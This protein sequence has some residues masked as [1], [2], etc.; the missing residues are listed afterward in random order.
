MIPVHISKLQ[1]YLIGKGRYDFVF[2]VTNSTIQFL[3]LVLP[4]LFWYEICIQ[5]RHHIKEAYR[6]HQNDK[7]ISIEVFANIEFDSNHAIPTKIPLIFVFAAFSFED[8]TLPDEK[9]LPNHPVFFSGLLFFLETL[10]QS[11][12][13]NHESLIIHYQPS[14]INH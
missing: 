1:K 9:M 10:K 11:A 7:G 4:L 3:H 12:I 14:L 6:H 2:T 5:E 8:S 13:I